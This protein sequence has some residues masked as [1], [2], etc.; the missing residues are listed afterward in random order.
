MKAVG[1]EILNELRII[2]IYSF[3]S[4][5]K[6]VTSVW[7]RLEKGFGGSVD[8]AHLSTCG[9]RVLT[10]TPSSS[11]DTRF[12][13]RNRNAPFCTVLFRTEDVGSCLPERLDQ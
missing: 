3:P 13:I 6:G 4:H 2:D 10:S 1:C 12:S 11:S 7:V 9:N 5:G 8:V